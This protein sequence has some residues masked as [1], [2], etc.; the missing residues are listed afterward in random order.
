MTAEGSATRSGL[1][2]LFSQALTSIG[3]LTLKLDPLSQA[4]LDALEGICVRFEVVTPDRE[5]LLI[6]VVRVCDGQLVV[7]TL[8]SHDRTEDSSDDKPNAIV[9][10]PAGD[11]LALLS[12]RGTSSRVTIDGD[13]QVLADLATLLKHFE[14]DLAGPMGEILGTQAA[15]NLVGIAEAAIAALKST[16][17]SLGAVAR[18]GA[19]AR[20]LGNPEFDQMLGRL[21]ELQLRVDRLGARVRDIESSQGTG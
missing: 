5:D 9:T 21:E 6:T 7:A 4:R 2:E 14:P 1:E 15:D 20:Y 11:L 17:E 13:E 10:G 12:N 18:Q 8:G 19:Q 16:A 3:N